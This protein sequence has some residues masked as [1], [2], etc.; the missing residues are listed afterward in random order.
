MSG[1]FLEYTLIPVNA[2]AVN[3]PCVTVC[4]VKTRATKGSHNH[5]RPVIGFQ[6]M[7]DLQGFVLHINSHLIHRV[8]KL[9]CYEHHLLDWHYT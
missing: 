6:V 8:I 5:R 7:A 9:Q 1:S 3:T 2:G 4:A